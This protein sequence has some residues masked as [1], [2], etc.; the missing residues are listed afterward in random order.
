MYNNSIDKSNPG[1]KKLVVE[2]TYIQA[3]SLE[4]SPKKVC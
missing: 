1:S 3:K 2:S 4:I